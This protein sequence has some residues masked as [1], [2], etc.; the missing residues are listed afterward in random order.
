VGTRAISLWA[1]SIATAVLSG[2]LSACSPRDAAAPLA[3]SSPLI[4]RASLFA[5]PVRYGGQLS[6]NGERVAFVAPRDGVANVW[7]LSVG[8]MEDARPATDD[9]GRGV[10]S[11]RWAYD[12][13]TLLYLHDEEGDETWRL[14]AVDADGGEPRALTPPASHAEIIGLSAADPRNVIIA[15]WQA[16]RAAAD[17]FRVELESGE[18]TLMYRNGGGYSHFVVDRQNRLRLALRRLESGD[19]EL[20]TRTAEGGWRMLASVPLQDALSTRPLAM[21]ANG[22]SA[23]LLDST[24]RDRAALVRIDLETGEKDVL[25]ESARADVVDVWLE[26]ATNEPLAWA[27][28]YLSREWRG[29]DP[30]AS[31]DLDFLDRQL[32]GDF[33]VI[34]RSGDNT[35]WIVVEE[36]PTTPPRS[37]L[38]DRADRA[39]RRLT[40]LFRHFPAL[41]DIPLQAMAPVEI[42]ARDGLTLVSYLTLPPGTDENGD[43]RP[44]QPTPLV[45][46]PHDGPYDR[47]S[48]GFNA[49]HQW[50]ANRGYAVLS[51][52][53][54]G[55]SGFGTAF[56]NAANS[57]WGD[58]VQDDLVDAVQWAVDSG[59]AQADRVGILGAGYG[60]YAALGAAVAHPE[61]YRCAASFGAP[62][63]LATAIQASPNREQMTALLGDASTLR[64]QSPLLRADRVANPVFLAMGVRDP[65]VSRLESD[66]F[67]QALRHRG[68]NLTYLVFPDEGRE[69]ARAAN[70]GSYLAVLEHFL[71]DCLGGRV[72]PV[73]GAFEGAVFYAL[74]GA[75]NVPGLSAFA[76]EPAAPATATRVSAGQRAA[77]AEP[78]PLTPPSRAVPD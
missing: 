76:R 15:L 48:F 56:L 4:A 42:N 72:E 54:R 78:E 61:R 62:L 37:Y 45:V 75:A 43:G 71:G 33:K 40:L 57:N 19:S 29:L 35:R 73:G 31:A 38:Y 3:A 70:R 2:G 53:T 50:L 9:R 69:L 14:F 17:V 65:R 77:R 41:E 52:N 30:D 46:A 60:G 16:D 74:D 8:A 68:V 55:S 58:R 47:D 44:E 6:P 20:V 11:P 26:P 51:V 63:N 7:V 64:A 13:A 67:A 18:R 59:I 49:L 36:G 34:S 32:L 22:R 12:N 23:L 1:G 10:R 66:V 27:A 5:D 39:G 25:G 21:E 28:E 24:G